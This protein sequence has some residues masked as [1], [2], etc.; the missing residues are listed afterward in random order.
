[1]RSSHERLRVSGRKVSRLAY[2]A[3]TVLVT[4][5]NAFAL[6]SLSPESDRLPNQEFAD[7]LSEW[8]Q[9]RPQDHETRFLYARV[10]TWDE[11]W[12][13]SIAE[14]DALLAASPD[15]VDYLFGKAQ[16]LV[17]SDRSA[18][19]SP[20]LERARELAPDYEDVRLL[21]ERV[22]AMNA[23]SGSIATSEVEALGATRNKRT[24]S[25]NFRQGS[26]NPPVRRAHLMAAASVDFLDNGFDN[27]KSL[28]VN[29]DY[30]VGPGR[31][32]YGELRSTERFS[33]HDLDLT[34]GGHLSDGNRW[35]GF[36]QG[37]VGPGADIL[38]RWTAMAGVRRALPNDWGVELSYRHSEYAQTYG[39]VMA[40]GIERY[41]RSYRFAYGLHRG[42]A[43]DAKATFSHVIRVD[44]YY[45]DYDYIGLIVAD[46]EE[47]ESIGLDRLL[48]SD[49]ETYGLVG[50]HW[51]TE[52]WAIAWAAEYH[53]QGKV[54]TRQGIYVGLKRRF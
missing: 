36:V 2:L 46:G 24:S 35:S 7:R 34:L 32:V 54:Y 42:K 10:L 22:L 4:H 12:E 19:A 18:E 51:L 20:L 50:Q 17:W 5:V 26:S 40:L 43:E 30:R 38:P 41:W 47:A 8:L 45:G 31:V 44:Y 15:N 1:M 23:A 39:D 11:S 52:S 3:T 6:E 13:Q 9:L 28:F 14:Y 21:H 27:W 49:I 16:V 37:S 53:K 29:G 48:V 25:A 33:D